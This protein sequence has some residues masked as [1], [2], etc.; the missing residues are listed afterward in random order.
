MHTKRLHGLATSRIHCHEGDME[1]YL[2]L[3][4][5]FIDV[6]LIRIFSIIIAFVGELDILVEHA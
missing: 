1:H 2:L 3:F 5:D 4:S 6:N